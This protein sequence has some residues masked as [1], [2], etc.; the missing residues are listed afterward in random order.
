MSSARRSL[1]KR[2]TRLTFDPLP[3]SS[4]QAASLPDQVKGKASAVSFRGSKKP[5][6]QDKLFSYQH[7][8]NGAPGPSSSPAGGQ[9]AL[10]RLPTPLNSSQRDPFTEPG[11]PRARPSSDSPNDHASSL[12]PPETFDLTT[13][14]MTK[15][16]TNA[17]VKPVD[18]ARTPPSKKS[19]SLRHRGSAISTDQDNDIF[20]QL[21]SPF[22]VVVH[23]PSKVKAP[24]GASTMLPT[25]SATT[26]QGRREFRKKKALRDDLDDL[27]EE[28][29]SESDSDVQITTGSAHKRSAA[30]GKEKARDGSPV[31]RSINPRTFI[32]GGNSGAA[33]L[34]GGRRPSGISSAR[35]P[36][37]SKRAKEPAQTR[38]SPPRRTRMSSARD[39]VFSPTRTFRNPEPLIIPS[40]SEMVDVKDD[41]EDEPIRS[42][43]GKRDRRDSTPL[44]NSSPESFS[45]LFQSPP[46]RA[47]HTIQE[48]Q[49]FE[50]VMSGARP[51]E[52]SRSP[53]ALPSAVKR[54]PHASETGL[55]IRTSPLQPNRSSSSV[56]RRQLESE[57]I[58]QDLVD[59][60]E[61]DESDK[62][63]KA[64]AKAKA[65]RTTRQETKRKI[66]KPRRTEKQKALDRIRRRH[67]AKNV[68]DS[69]SSSEEE[70]EESAAEEDMAA[71]RPTFNDD[72]ESDFVVDEGDD[73]IGAP[74]EQMPLEFTRQA[75][76]K[77]SDHFRI[78]IEWMV[79]NNL[80]HSF[81]RQDPI[82]RMA[83]D[84]LN[85]N[86]KG[87]SQSKFISSV[88]DREFTTA[89]KARP[90]MYTIDLDDDDEHCRA[91]NRAGH[92]ATSE[93][94]FDGKPYDFDTLETLSEEEDDEDD[95][96]DTSYDKDHNP[97][98]KPGRRWPLGVT[99]KD[100]A[101]TAHSLLHWKYQ[102]NS[103]VVDFLTDE[104]H[105]T[106]EQILERNSWSMRKRLDE[107]NHV[108]D[109]M[110]ERGDVQNLWQ[111]FKLMI[112]T[113]SAEKKF[114]S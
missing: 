45:S 2:Q 18:P 79:Q 105:N 5:N 1:R 114:V 32:R 58:A 106:Q 81:P 71:L 86:V 36:P 61:S 50:A 89:L 16:S 41:D 30:R 113:A 17:G 76:M 27:F 78:A 55:P 73:T 85:D 4:P 29:Q 95:E 104:G 31:R 11:A 83:F 101:E 35:K 8:A 40:D 60:A 47:K 111:H 48:P 46:K 94:W 14:K 102:V 25:G 67:G 90:T 98:A 39:E 107:A 54:R 7:T 80:N 68:P 72:Y 38:S 15:K 6:Y 88:W 69:S 84:K 44:Q 112:R 3:S 9:P 109:D 75:H 26:S 51:Q 70:S 49:S 23:T 53:S 91:C 82:Y 64:K 43:L 56:D 33:P 100:N 97:V 10:A 96:S 28:P 52:Q 21:G 87:Y 108:F 24:G 103:W 13:P 57:D 59:L 92:T 62:P 77:L 74:L 42:P 63:K 93:C 65:K 12:Q 66:K 37:L 99:C 110:K 20:E 34:P 19:D 22:A